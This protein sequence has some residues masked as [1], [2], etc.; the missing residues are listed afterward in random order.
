LPPQ[1][2]F[3]EPIEVTIHHILDVSHLVTGTM[4]LHHLVR[5]KNIGANLTSPG[6][7]PLFTILPLHLR[8]FFVFF[9]LEQ[10]RYQQ[11][12]LMEPVDFYDGG[13]NISVDIYWERFFGLLFSLG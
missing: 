12:W 2:R 13:S 11:R 1:L 10:R 8:S 3:Y 6:Y 7:F 4:I 5:L 9:D